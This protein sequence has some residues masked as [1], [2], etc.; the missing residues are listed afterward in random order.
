MEKTVVGVLVIILVVAPIVLTLSVSDVQASLSWGN[1]PVDSAANVGQWSSLALDSAGRPHISY[2]DNSTFDLKYARWNGS[3]WAVE[4]VDSDGDVGRYS[5]IALDSAGNPRIAY[6]NVSNGDLKYAKDINP[7]PNITSWVTEVVDNA[8]NLGYGPSLALD[9]A[10]NPRI[11][12]NDLSQYS[13]ISQWGTL[14]AG[15]GEFNNTAGI[16]VDNAGYV[17]VSDRSNNRVQ[18][19][20]SNGTYV[21]QWGSLGTGNGQFNATSGI[22]VDNAGYVYVAD[23]F[24]CR[25]QKFTVD[26]TYVKQ[27]GSNGTGDGQFNNVL[28]EIAVD[29]AGYVYAADNGNFRVQKFTSD[30]VYVTQWGTNGT[31]ND[32]FRG[33]FGVA[34]DSSGYVYTT[35]WTL[36]RVQKFTNDGTYVTQWGTTGS[37]NG[38]FRSPRAIAV[39]SSGSVYVTDYNNSRVQKFMSNG[40]FMVQWGGFGYAPGQFY[41]TRGVAVNGSGYVYVTDWTLYRVQRFAP[42]GNGLKY[43][44]WNGSAWTIQTLESGTPGWQSLKLDSSGNP[45]ISYCNPGVMDLKYAWMVD[46]GWHYTTVDSEG[47]LG[48]GTSLALRNGN[49]RIA[50]Y[51][52]AFFNASSPTYLKYAE[53]TF[54]G[55]SISWVISTIG[56]LGANGNF[57]MN[58][59][60]LALD[61]AGNPHICYYNASGASC[62]Q[63]TSWTGSQWFVETVDSTITNVGLGSSLAIDSVGNPHIGYHDFVMG[64]LKYATMVDF[65]V[66]ISPPSQTIVA[67]Y[68]TGYYVTVVR[69]AGVLGPVSLTL[70]NLPSNVGSYVFLPASATPDFTSKLIIWTIKSA[71]VGTYNLTV[72][73]NYMGSTRT[74]PFKLTVTT[75]FNIILDLEPRTVAR[76]STLTLSGQLTPGRA[77]TLRLYYRLPHETGTWAIATYLYTN[78]T[79]HFKAAASVPTSLPP[80]DYDLMAV[81][82]EEA[83]GAYVASPVKMITIT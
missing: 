47:N 65:S 34:A 24:N 83:T 1:R 13:Y 77:T 78:S 80:G 56:F 37:A 38:Q 8:G 69:F 30:G 25:I 2:Y 3:A 48:A 81:W 79:G 7:N 70:L 29:N 16:A 19:F 42:N 55:G 20:T 71:P 41:N 46:N 60:S 54:S 12:Y 11:A 57:G 35:D 4:T 52:R 51:D 36:N 76:G 17:Y 61:S 59:P 32:Q 6:N 40:T 18:K 74:A 82:F 5:S 10:G 27:W 33:V 22:A 49:P 31:G 44:A 21:T 64:D 43:A 45:H 39:D 75:P 67:G 63:Y 26:G 68:Q 62:L 9:S 50:Y 58:N 72:S 28:F 23:S 15:N 73:A 66:A 53:G 14:G